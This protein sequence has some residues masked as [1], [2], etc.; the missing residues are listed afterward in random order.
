MTIFRPLI[1]AALIAGLYNGAASAQDAA[2]PAMPGLLSAGGFLDN[3]DPDIVVSIGAGVSYGSAY[4]GSGDMEVNPTGTFRLDLIRFPNGWTF[5]S[6][7][8]VGFDEGFG[9]RGSAR[10]IGSRTSSDYPE[11]AGLNDV[12]WTLE[13]GLGVGYEQRNYRVFGDAR[14]GFHGHK[15][16]VGQI[17]ADLVSR[18]MRGLTINFGPRVDFGDSTYSSTYFGITPAESVASGLPVYSAGSGLVSAGLELNAI[19]QF[20]PR[21]GIEGRVSWD[22]LLNSAADSPITRQGSD[23]QLA[24]SV[25][26][27]RRIAIDF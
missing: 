12:P 23:D 9:L 25:N 17:G 22:R 11:L 20:N 19:Y 18:P 24:I 6:T 4:P 13:L 14:Y 7:R 5:G 26:L 1:A 27:V 10:Y 3:P 16:F 21:W 15:G 2:R 8:S